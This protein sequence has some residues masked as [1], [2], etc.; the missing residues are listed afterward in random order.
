MFWQCL[1]TRFERVAMAG[2][3]RCRKATVAGW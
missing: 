1:S 3:V 2:G